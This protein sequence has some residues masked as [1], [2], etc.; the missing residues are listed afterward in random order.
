[1]RT[2]VVVGRLPGTGVPADR[3][4]RTARRK[5]DG[6]DRD[7]GACCR[8]DRR[9]NEPRRPKEM[10]HEAECDRARVNK[11]GTDE[12]KICDV[13]H[14]GSETAVIFDPKEIDSR[15]FLLSARVFLD[16]LGQVAAIGAEPATLVLPLHRQFVWSRTHLEV[17]HSGHGFRCR[18]RDSHD[19]R[20]L[21]V[22]RAGQSQFLCHACGGDDRMRAASASQ[23]KGF[24]MSF[25]VMHSRSV[26]VCGPFAAS[27]LIDASI[28]AL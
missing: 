17:H 27:A 23:S 5:G 26:S 19:A 18:C 14:G 10:K 1:M 11:R 7:R 16:F 20:A 12:P 2:I 24:S 9:G 13:R 3:N 22:T 4:V 28:S 15:P 21:D 25:C 8:A 6:Q